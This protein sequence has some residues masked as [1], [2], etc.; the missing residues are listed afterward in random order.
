MPV[1]PTTAYVSLETVSTLIR[2]IVND[3]IFSQA[4]EI[5]TDTSNLEFPLLNDALEWF[6]NEVSNHGITTF[7]KETVLTPILP[8]AVVDPGIQVNISDMGY[9]D[10]AAN[11]AQPQV[12]T[13][14]LVPEFLW[15]R[16]T[17]STAE[18]SRMKER[19]GGL[20]S[21]PQGT[22]LGYWEW[23]QDQINLLGATQSNDIKLRYKGSHAFFA[24]TQDTLLFRGGTGPI[25]Y[26]MVSTYLIS[27]NPDA[28][29]LAQEEA[30]MRV[31]QLATRNARMKQ[32]TAITRRS[33]GS[34][35]DSNLQWRPPHN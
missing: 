35:V 33:Y 29:K 25:A 26:K 21:I 7:T 12:P 20:P 19:I 11:H 15:E 1:L 8:I 9:F 5:L 34:Q 17:G 2:A 27:K 16:Q 30:N 3:M 22:I 18:W 31:S 4:G 13:D 14:L 6:Q 10:G 23:R 24:T 28:A 32:Q